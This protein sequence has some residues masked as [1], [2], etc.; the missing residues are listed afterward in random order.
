M[1]TIPKSYDQAAAR[2]AAWACALL[3][4][5]GFRT[6]PPAVLAYYKAPVGLLHTGHAGA[7]AQAMGIVERLFFRDGDFHAYQ[8][9]PTPRQGRSY[10]NGWLAWGA[11]L[12]GAYHLSEPALDRLEAGLDARTGGAA[13]DDSAPVAERTY[14]AGGTA[15]VANALLAAGRTDAA[16]RAGGFLRELFDTQAVDA[17]RIFLA[18][19]A[20]GAPIDPVQRGITS[21]AESLL[22]DLSKPA[23]IC[24]IFGFSLRVFARLYRATQDRAWLVTAERVGDWI[25][26][27]D[28]SLYTN[29][30]NGKVAWGAAELFG[31]T[32]RREW[33]DLA[34]RIGDWVAGEQGDDGV[35]V[36]RPQFASACEQ[37]LAVSLDTSIE[38][39]FY[40]VDIQ[41]AIALPHARAGLT[42]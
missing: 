31:A 18:R 34:H 42:P 20:Q 36:R 27:A 8:G 35:W 21:G 11:H 16:I 1:T 39:M 14:P 41:R 29:I 6:C 33:L 2:T 12:L 37:P 10:R 40:M 7:A 24:W 17:T 13:D 23:Q 22:F 4:A 26:H 28:A 5:D 15:S 9:D 32:G 3:E 25:A 19:D 30:T 38:R